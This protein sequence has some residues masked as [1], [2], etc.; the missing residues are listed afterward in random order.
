MRMAVP[1]ESARSSTKATIGHALARRDEPPVRA[2]RYFAKEA[3]AAVAPPHKTHRYRADRRG[4]HH[5]QNDTARAFHGV[6]SGEILKRRVR[7]D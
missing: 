4:T 6:V 2:A 7:S 1:V 3:G 5:G